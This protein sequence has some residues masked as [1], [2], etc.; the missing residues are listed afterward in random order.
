MKAPLEIITAFLLSLMSLSVYSQAPPSIDLDGHHLSISE[1]IAISRDHRAITLSPD[2][3]D[4]VAKSHKLLLRAAEHDLA[5]YGLTRGVGLNKDKKIFQGTQKLSPALIKLSQ[6]YNIRAIRAHSAGI[7]EESSNELVRAAML[8]RLNTLLLGYA[9]V[10]T[11]V[12]ALYAAFLNNDITPI[13]PERGSMGEAD[14]TILSHIGLAM[15][16]EGEV[17]YKGKRMLAAEALGKANLAPLR[18]CAKDALSILSSNAYSTA[19]SVL[20]IADLQHL[21]EIAY[22]IFALNFEGYNGNIEVFLP[23]VH[24]VRPYHYETQA[25]Q[26]IL[27]TMA[28]SYLWSPSSARALQEPLSYKTAAQSF[29]IVEESLDEVRNKLQVQMNSSDD[30]PAVV[31]TKEVKSLG[32]SAQKYVINDLD[33]KGAILPTAN[34]SPLTW[35]VSMEK[36]TNALS[37][38]SHATTQQ[39][40]RLVDPEFSHLPRFLAP[41]EKVLA[42]SAIQKSFVSLDT[43][44][45]NL[46]N[47]VSADSFPVAGDIEDTATNS[48]LVATHLAKIICNLHYQLGIQLMHGAQAVDL[49]KRENPKLRLSNSTLHLFKAYRHIIPM[50]TQDRPLTPDINKSAEFLYH[51]RSNAHFF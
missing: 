24:Q 13:L 8:I 20:A 27:E 42:F 30:N 6:D 10:Q 17:K 11:K 14:I 29:A 3:L 37:H 46:A 28:G 50:I 18:P 26:K 32:E 31:L 21:L 5:I 45:R 22:P 2:S 51:Y 44:N 15:M 12:V 49:R 16:G 33:I 34:Y 39:M 1:V 23:V 38:F 7:G 19:I 36:L 35:V 47:P 9:G 40:I 43:E 48:A 25:A 41:D 4:I